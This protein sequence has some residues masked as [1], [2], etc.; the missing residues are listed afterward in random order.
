MKNYTLHAL[1]GFILITPILLGQANAN[2]DQPIAA[3]PPTIPEEARKHF[4]MGTTLFKDAKAGDDF[5]QV[6]NEFKQVVD[7]APQW[8]D[9]RYN[10]ALAREAAG[11]YSGAMADLKLYQ[12][13]KLSESEAR[14]VQDK[15]Y[16]LEAKTVMTAKKQDEQQ[17]AAAA[18]AAAEEQKQRDY[19]RKIGFLAGAWTISRTV[20]GGPWNGEKTTG[21]A[22]I[23]IADKAVVIYRIYEGRRVQELKGTIEGDDYTSI[24]WIL[25]ADRTPD[26]PIDV[27]IDNAS[28]MHWKRP[29]TEAGRN[30]SS[31]TW[32]ISYDVQ[33]SK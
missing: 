20:K 4:V 23:T 25:Q 12:Q 30:E 1:L 15:I 13:F 26:Y 16:I 5:S 14:T 24:K 3:T 33:L 32:Q 18:A 2:A 7:L 10:L 21:P 8:P 27:S 31:W 9:A 22:V 17:K 6:V 19:Q 11:D 29:V 28:K